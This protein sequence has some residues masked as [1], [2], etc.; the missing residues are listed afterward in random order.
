M[1]GAEQ[2]GGLAGRSTYRR[3]HRG[4]RPAVDPPAPGL[5]WGWDRIRTRRRSTPRR[6]PTTGRR[7]WGYN[8]RSIRRRR[9]YRRGHCSRYCSDWDRTTRPR[10]SG[11]GSARWPERSPRWRH[12]AIRPASADVCHTSGRRHW[13]RTSRCQPPDGP[14]C[15]SVA[16]RGS[17]SA[18]RRSRWNPQTA[19]RAR[20]SQGA[21]DCPGR[22]LPKPTNRA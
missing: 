3:H 8:R 15:R 18:A 5:R 2:A 13:L 22:S 1:T 14:A 7:R 11:R 16:D 21:T 17:R 19:A 4:F 10:D 20:G 6:S 9:R 12:A